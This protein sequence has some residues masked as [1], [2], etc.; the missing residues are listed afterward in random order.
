VRHRRSV[1]GFD[2]RQ[3]Q[4]ELSSNDFDSHHFEQ[5]QFRQIGEIDHIS[6]C[7]VCAK[8]PRFGSRVGGGR[9]QVSRFRSGC[10]TLHGSGGVAVMTMR[11]EQD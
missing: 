2:F 8:S 7:F 10:P 9:S 5:I 6:T 1:A 3:A 4:L 11:M